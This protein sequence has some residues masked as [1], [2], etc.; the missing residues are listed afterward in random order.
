M[1]SRAPQGIP[2]DNASEMLRRIHLLRER[3]ETVD[4]RLAAIEVQ[5]SAGVEDFDYRYDG[6]GYIYDGGGGLDLPAGRELTDLP[7]ALVRLYAETDGATFGRVELS[8]AADFRAVTAVDSLGE[9]AY[10]GPLLE[11]GDCLENKIFLDTDTG[12]VFVYDDLYFKWGLATGFLLECADV[13]EFVATVALGPRYTEL[14]GTTNVDETWWRTDAWYH[15]LAELGL[16]PPV[17]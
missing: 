5:L 13:A 15:Y 12:A 4:D 16:C 11:I 1:K 14:L 6:G 2:V 7:A 3:T 17:R 10:D 8:R 9:S